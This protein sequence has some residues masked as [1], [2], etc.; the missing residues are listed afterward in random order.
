LNEGLPN[1]PGYRFAPI[2]IIAAVTSIINSLYSWKSPAQGTVST[3]QTITFLSIINVSPT[4][5]TNTLVATTTL[6]KT[7][8]STY[9]NFTTV[10]A[11]KQV[12]EWYTVLS[13][14]AIVAVLTILGAAVVGLVRYLWIERSKRI[15]TYAELRQL[16]TEIERENHARPGEMIAHV[17]G[18]K[19]PFPY[20]VRSEQSNAI[21]EVMRKRARYIR[22]TTKDLW[23]NRTITKQSSA[24]Y[25]LGQ[26]GYDE[27]ILDDFVNDVKG[28]TI[29]G[30]NAKPR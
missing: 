26:D 30:Q 8:Y 10:A 5:V 25:G 16:I 14:P 12:S 6:L 19:G 13:A 18:A 17:T 4:T 15:Q 7:N 9:L 1:L 28:K 21:T 27:I 22:Q 3:T 20:R 11:T 29:V 2:Y 24:F 23:N